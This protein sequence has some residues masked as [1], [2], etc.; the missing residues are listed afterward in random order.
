MSSLPLEMGWSERTNLQVQKMEA[1]IEQDLSKAMAGIREQFRQQFDVDRVTP[2]NESHASS[3]VDT[4]NCIAGENGFSHSSRDQPTAQDEVLGGLARLRQDLEAERARQSSPTRVGVVDPEWHQLQVAATEASLTDVRRDLLQ[5]QTEIANLRREMSLQHEHYHVRFNAF[6]KTFMQMHQDLQELRS[7]IEK[8][9]DSAKADTQLLGQSFQQDIEVL[10]RRCEQV[11][12]FSQNIAEA[13]AAKLEQLEARVLSIENEERRQSSHDP[14]KELLDNVAV[15]PH[16]EK[17]RTAEQSRLDVEQ[18]RQEF[19][20]SMEEFREHIFGEMDMLRVRMEQH[21]GE[22]IAEDS[23]RAEVQGGDIERSMR[24][25]QE[26]GEDVQHALDALRVDLQE[27]IQAQASTTTSSLRG[28]LSVGCAEVRGE[29]T[30]RLDAYESSLQETKSELRGLKGL[31]FREESGLICDR[32]EAVELDLHEVIQ[33]AKLLASRF[34][35]IKANAPQF[36]RVASSTSNDV[37]VPQLQANASH[38]ASVISGDLK[39]SLEKLVQEVGMKLES[40]EAAQSF[41][42]SD[43]D[44]LPPG[45]P[46]L[47]Y[48]SD[49]QSPSHS[50]FQPVHLKPIPSSAGGSARFTRRMVSTTSGAS[51]AEALL[52]EQLSD[53]LSRQHGVPMP[54]ASP[55]KVERK[56]HLSSMTCMPGA[57]SPRPPQSPDAVNQVCAASSSF[58]LTGGRSSSSGSYP[59]AY[60][61]WHPGYMPSRGQ[62]GLPTHQESPASQQPVALASATAQRTLS[63]VMRTRVVAAQRAVSPVVYRQGSLQRVA[64]PVRAT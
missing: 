15:E 9:G 53:A 54:F 45:P 5:Q 34:E 63:P 52:R 21:S 55:G 3:G 62:Q 14:S 31:P 23:R 16:D 57:T 30:A 51:Q 2:A 60:H 22:A 38:T 64:S 24:M 1:T 27:S 61:L 50:G 7:S 46:L 59:P 12:Q 32:L 8:P 4:E 41:A 20:Q 35:E 48:A 43:K 58:P 10:F 19:S 39:E 36:D 6:D 37:D 28:H 11:E 44:S 13:A 18:I 17:N 40:E 49:S 42:D 47:S 33:L 25:V 56:V 29:L 26:M